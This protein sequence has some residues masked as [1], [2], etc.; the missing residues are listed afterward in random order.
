MSARFHVL[1][2]PEPY[3]LRRREAAA[4]MGL[5][6][7]HFVKAVEC[8]LIPPA[9]DL[10]GVKVWSRKALEQALDGQRFTAPNPW[11]EE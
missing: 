8:G 2:R 5:S 7:N 11:D 1:P 4:Y 3:G 10:A 9:T 6:E